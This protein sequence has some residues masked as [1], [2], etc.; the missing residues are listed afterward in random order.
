MPRVP[1]SAMEESLSVSDAII[2][3]R[4]NHRDYQIGDSVWSPCARLGY[5][6]S[7]IVS[8][9][10]HTSSYFVSSADQDPGNAGQYSVQRDAVRPLYDCPSRTFEDNCEMVHLDDANILENLKKRYAKDLIYTYTANVILAVNP[11]KTMHGLYSNEQMLR[12]RGRNPGNLPAHPYAITDLAYRQLQ[13]DRKNQALVI[14][15]ESGAGKTETAKITM[16]YLTSMSRT[17]AALGSQIQERILSANP[18]LESF[19]NA[20]T[21][22]NA[23]SSRFGKYNEM[24]FNPVGSLVGAG[25][26]TFLLES[27][28]VVF[29]QSGEKNYHVFYQLLAGMDDNTIDRLLLDPYGTYKLLH[30]SGTKPA[31]EG[32]AEAQKF[33]SQFNQ[34][35]EALSC[36]ANQDLQNDIWDVVGA[37]VH[38]GEVDFVE[39]EA[40]QG[41]ASS[42]AGASASGCPGSAQAAQPLVEVPVEGMDALYNATELLG[43]E[44]EH[45]ERILKFKETC[46]RHAGGRLSVFKCPRTLTQ[47][48]Q[49]L[50]S[51]IKVLYKRLFDSLVKKMNDATS[52]SG[53][54]SNEHSYNSIGTLDIYGFERLETNSFEQLCINLA[55]E[56]LQQFFVEEVLGAEQ[57]MY[58]EERLSV[59]PM[60]LPDSTPV[61]TGIRKVMEILNEHS[62]R[63][64]RNLG[65]TKED[66]DMKFCEHLHR[67]LVQ[68]SNR[69]TGPIMALKLRANRNG[70]GLGQHDGFQICHYAGPVS[71]STKGWIDKN[72]DSLVPELEQVLAQ[73]K[74]SVVRDMADQ[75]GMTAASGERSNSLSS[76]YL[77]NLD[78]LLNTL[79][80][81]S[82]HYIRCFNPNQTRSPGAFDSKYVLDQVIQCGTVQLVKIMHH[83]YPH[84]CFLGD[85]RERLKRMLPPEFERYSHRDF[86]HAVL[87]AWNMDESQWTLGTRRLFLKAGQLRVL[88]DLK[89]LG[90]QASQEVIKSICRRFAKKKVKAAAHA[91]EIVCYLQKSMKKWRRDRWLTKLHNSVRV[92]ARLQRW[93]C[94][95][96]ATLY[97]FEPTEEKATVDRGILLKQLVDRRPLKPLD[98]TPPSK[99][100]IT[101]NSCENH[102][103]WEDSKEALRAHQRKAS[104]SVLCFDGQR[105]KCIK[106]NGKA[107]VQQPDATEDGISFGRALED[108]REVSLVDSTDSQWGQAVPLHAVTPDPQKRIVCMCQH[109]AKSDVFATCNNQNQV[110]VWK[111]RGTAS[112]G[113]SQ[114]ATTMQAAFQYMDARPIIQ[115]CFLHQEPE[116]ANGYMMIL[117]A[118][119]PEKSW[120]EMHF[121]SVYHDNCF[122][123]ECIQH[124]FLDSDQ[125]EGSMEHFKNGFYITHF[126][127]SH[128]G[129]VLVVAGNL[130]LHLFAVSQDAA[131]Q[132]HRVVPI[133][134]EIVDALV[135][136]DQQ[137][138]NGGTVVSV[139]SLPVDSHNDIIVFGM[140]SGELRA[141]CLVEENGAVS[142]IDKRSGRMVRGSHTKGIPIRSVVA[143][144]EPQGETSFAAG[145]HI[146][147]LIMCKQP[148]SPYRFIS[149]GDDGRMLTWG[150]DQHRS[151]Q[152]TEVRSALGHSLVAARS[153]CLVPS[154]LVMFDNDKQRIVAMDRK[155]PD[156]SS[157]CCSLLS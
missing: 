76:L 121:I 50:Q 34:L 39:M 127:M 78:K 148:V 154:V 93:L 117:L 151:W 136:K 47:A 37:L 44:G 105:V 128:S 111:W 106:L 22:M 133:E 43:L 137:C 107:F 27:S 73:G 87:I 152:P 75:Q 112:S 99:L 71:Y 35:K 95:A 42:A 52:H 80:Q 102:G 88:E 74:K 104:E 130:F 147:Q 9:D 54:S 6:R 97:G 67:E 60:E 146:S 119:N 58:E 36:F 19:G 89:D 145:N 124:L 143:M 2:T 116:N 108:L 21:V 48:R 118:R 66:K 134:K 84:R 4:E 53:M 83:G 153:S 59:L 123:L 90:G 7:T 12:Y 61:V 56:R 11:Y 79:K 125:D 115:M 15:G 126:G 45:L 31:A 46:V 113:T 142:I 14:S 140:S 109:S 101:F 131:G 81:C 63:A 32:S 86:L 139:C 150:L 5:R 62:L 149:I 16:N 85:L 51:I 155:N 41:D 100:F 57:R 26:K 10:H 3:P 135:S 65:T 23:N 129:S 72:N 40:T 8:V 28:R 138:P 122:R 144:H 1:P 114:E 33:A 30:S 24:Y 25:I 77:D 157:K 17:D 29:Q 156:V 82:V 92:A 69:Q 20:S 110:M 103:Y 18:I 64:S 98:V 96:R 91:I 49:T 120:L 70:T 94:K 38:L 68:G 13:R 55:N 141:V 132:A